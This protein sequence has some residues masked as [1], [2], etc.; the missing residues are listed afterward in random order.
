M[1]LQRLTTSQTVFAYIKTPKSVINLNNCVYF[2]FP[3]DFSDNE[4]PFTTIL[5]YLQATNL[6]FL[7]NIMY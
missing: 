3:K 6:F 1:H 7:K 2:F 5:T 4:M